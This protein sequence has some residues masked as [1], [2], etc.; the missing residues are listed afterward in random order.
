MLTRIR[1]HRS[2]AAVAPL[3]AGLLVQHAS[4]SWAMGAFAATSAV[5]AVLG[6]LMPGLRHDV[7]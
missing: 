3:I 6:L 5:A 1:R 7:P 2:L 4:G